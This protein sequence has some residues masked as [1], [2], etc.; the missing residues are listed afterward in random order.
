MLDYNTNMEKPKNLINEGINDG[1]S[2]AQENFLKI[3]FCSTHEYKYPFPLLIVYIL[4]NV[5]VS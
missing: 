3:N 4:I 1:S 5:P 2:R